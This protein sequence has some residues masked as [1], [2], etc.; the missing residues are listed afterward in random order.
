[1]GVSYRTVVFFNYWCDVYGLG[2]SFTTQ[3]C[4]QLFRHTRSVDLMDFSA[5]NI[6][7]LL[8]RISQ[9][10]V[11]HG[12]TLGMLVGSVAI[13]ALRE[14]RLRS[15]FAAAFISCLASFV[16]G[17]LTIREEE[18]HLFAVIAI[19][20]G[21]FFGS[22]VVVSSIATGGVAKWLIRQLIAILVFF[23][24]LTVVFTTFGLQWGSP[25]KPPQLSSSDRRRLARLIEKQNPF[26]L[27]AGKRSTVEFSEA[28]AENLMN[29]GLTF[30]P[31]THRADIAFLQRTQRLTIDTQ[32]KSFRRLGIHF[33]LVVNGTL[34]HDGDG[35]AFYPERMR[36]GDLSIPS[37][38]L[39]FCAPFRLN[40]NDT[41]SSLINMIESI[42]FGRGRIRAVCL[43]G[44]RAGTDDGSDDALQELLVA[45]GLIDDLEVS[46][47]FYVRSL[48]DLAE[49]DSDGIDFKNSIS[50]VFR[51]SQRRS[52]HGDARR[53][54]RAAIL[55]MSYLMGHRKIGRLIGGNLPNPSRKVRNTFRAMTLYGRSD[56][57]RHFTLSAAICILS[58][59][60]A[61]NDIGLLKEEFDADGGSGFS[62][63]DLA[64][65]RCGV[66][67]AN[68][69]TAGV[70]NQIQAMFLGDF[71]IGDFI[72]DPSQLPEGLS[73]DEF[74]RQFGGIEGEAFAELL[75]KIDSK[76]AGCRAY[77]SEL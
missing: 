33:R 13:F 53:E 26:R 61:S 55:A 31:G 71:T 66:A 63:A 44:D 62:F 59:E 7:L 48:I 54:N 34:A 57:L 19:L 39:D 52:R 23:T 11:I 25:E 60:R 45:L 22:W 27:A 40:H 3:A 35:I 21:C 77:Q 36:I 67:F 38:V 37:F 72:P 18:R 30:L 5:P 70:P 41:G 29:W 58:N 20:F 43:R 17:L 50:H 51:E 28:D 15:V 56:W 4:D 64:V 12:L 16:L 42:E 69:A 46:A 73:K 14:P 76:I 47:S 32:P 1:M 10:G 49:R 75:R 9:A 65:D 74:E 68:H 24:L 2:R 8:F 6:F